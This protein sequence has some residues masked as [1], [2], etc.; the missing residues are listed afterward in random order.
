MSNDKTIVEIN[1]EVIDLNDVDF[2][3][4][5]EEGVVNPGLTLMGPNGFR[6][7]TKNVRALDKVIEGL[8][9]MGVYVTHVLNREEMDMWRS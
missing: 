9:E 4:H 7:F 2:T 6:I 1:F 3:T 8:K 5:T